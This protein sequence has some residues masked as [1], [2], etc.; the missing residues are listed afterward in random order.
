M[1]QD[2]A[3]TAAWERAQFKHPASR[4]VGWEGTGHWLHQERPAEFNSL[5]LSWLAG[6]G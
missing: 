5:L 3:A 6:L 2:P 4:A 1:N